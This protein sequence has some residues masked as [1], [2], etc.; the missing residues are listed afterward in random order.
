MADPVM[1]DMV[2]NPEIWEQARL[3]PPHHL[4]LAITNY[5]N[6][7]CRHCW[8][9][10]GPRKNVTG[11]DPVT[12]RKT[13]RNFVR[14]GI[15]QLCL[16]GGEPL[17]HPNWFD[18]LHFAAAQ[19][20]LRSISLQTNATILGQPEARQLAAIEHP[21]F[22]IQVS[23]EGATPETN[24]LV[25]GKGRFA[26]A[27]DG[28]LQ[29]I[30]VGLGEQTS[31]AFTET[32]HNFAEL[33]DLIIKLRELGIGG[34]VSGT[35]V[36]AKRAASNL[37]R[38]PTTQQYC[39]LL[40]RYHQD[41]VFRLSYEAIGNVAALEWFKGRDNPDPTRCHCCQRLYLDGL[42]QLFPCTMLPF[43]RYAV[44]DAHHKSGEELAA[45]ATA[46]W[47]GL[48]EL[49]RRRP[50]AIRQCRACAHV[51]HCAGGCMARATGPDDDFPG[52]EDRCAL[53]KA[54]Y[55]WNPA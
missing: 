55:E 24:D 35:L 12:A 30:D 45:Q 29:L 8:P 54:V 7:T 13:I 40:A 21:E 17:T 18:I 4:T 28:L 44:A 20:E 16:T 25:R 50:H 42:G 33:P 2:G 27:W 11:L 36:L 6:L 3:S 41:E 19:P 37:L 1:G 49:S 15:E 47:A 51:L 38:L 48:G 26:A 39:D 9:E 52:V 31:V 23:L 14:L 22:E 43:S 32:E 5:C 46:L 10:C 53:R 34:L